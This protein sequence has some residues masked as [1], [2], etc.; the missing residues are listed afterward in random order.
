MIIEMAPYSEYG[1]DDADYG[2]SSEYDI[3][4]LSSGELMPFPVIR[5]RFARE[6]SSEGE[7]VEVS[8]DEEGQVIY[9][10]DEEEEEDEEDEKANANQPVIMSSRTYQV[11]M[12][13]ASMKRNIIV[14]VRFYY[15]FVENAVIVVISLANKVPHATHQMDTGSGKTQV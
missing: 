8:E 1:S 9:T 4:S 12:L 14:A 7:V 2:D 15:Y 5:D 10:D 6:C 11:E 3:T 13:E